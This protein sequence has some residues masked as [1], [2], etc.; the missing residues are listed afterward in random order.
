M[1]ILLLV[2]WLGE[3]TVNL[4]V[5]SQLTWLHVFAIDRRRKVEKTCAEK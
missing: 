3:K 2:A 1:R 5:F 4:A